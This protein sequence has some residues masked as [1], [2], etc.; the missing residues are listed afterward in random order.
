MLLTALVVIVVA[1]FVL[2]SILDY[3][4]DANS[5]AALDPA[6]KDLYD[7]DER[8]R[9]IAYAHERY[10]VSFFS[11]TFSSVV[12]ILALT[13][14]LFGKVDSWA[15]GI[16][17]NSILISLI[18]VGALSLIS[19]LLGFPFSIYST[20]VIE[21]RYGFNKTTPLTFI[22]DTIKGAVVS[23]VI[24]TPLLAAVVWFYQRFG[25]GFW[26]YAWALV[27]LFS[28]FMF[29]FGTSVILP[30]FN[31]LTPLE[32]GE[33]KKAILKYCDSQGYKV[34]RLFV[35]DGSRRSTKANAF[36]S[37]MGKSKMIVL[38]DT[39]IEK[40]SVEEVVA[41]L[42][43]EI[44]HYKLKHTKQMFI[45]STI[46]T[47]AIF[48]LLGWSLQFD[49]FARTLGAER[50]SFHISALVFFI[51]LT[52][53]NI[54]LGLLNNSLSRR[55]EFGADAFSKKTYKV[56]PMK[57]ALRKISTASLSNLTPHSVYVAF[58]YTHPPLASRLRALD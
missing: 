9:S 3:L 6:I 47:A 57:S 38:F 11:S 25:S 16:T 4:N 34:G 36:F 49:S 53:A 41:V 46:Q 29:M 8:K 43:H 18:F 30:L 42:A 5:G 10:R 26:I 7:Q 20:F 56:A 19:W 54:L 14:G 13:Q 23:L 58:N 44:G 45:A 52:P 12:M 50:I 21:E 48:A 28:V 17:N 27:A 55:N 37:G 40:L 22:Q 1:G 32:D 2:E 24:G 31:K 51:L 15:R 39:L 35:M 33:L